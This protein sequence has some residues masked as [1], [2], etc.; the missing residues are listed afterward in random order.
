MIERVKDGQCLVDLALMLTGAVEGVWAL[1]LRNGVGVTEQ[2]AHGLEIS[3]ESE[4]IETALTANRYK[5]EGICPATDV[6]PR[7]LA[8]LLGKEESESPPSYE[9][10]DGDTPPPQWTR[11]AVFGGEFASPFA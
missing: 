1:A 10:I 11:A 9:I 3:Y 2:L 8:A 4:D 7:A 6:S 5:A